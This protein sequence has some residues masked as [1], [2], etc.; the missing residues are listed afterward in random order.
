MVASPS[1]AEDQD[2][3][4]R[5][6]EDQGFLTRIDEDQGFLTCID[7]PLLFFGL[8]LLLLGIFLG[9]PYSTFSNM[10]WLLLV[11][12]GSLAAINVVR[13]Y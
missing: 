9:S 4:T 13:G 12:G 10:A 11:V 3:L 2:F 6:D 7:I 5:I 1:R 8:L